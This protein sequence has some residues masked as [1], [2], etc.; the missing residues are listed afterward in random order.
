MGIKQTQQDMT[1]QGHADQLI[2][3]FGQLSGAVVAFSGGVDS[4]VVAAAAHR[5]LGKRALAVTATS[6]SVSAAQL[7]WA[8]LTASEIGIRHVEVKTDEVQRL[9]YRE[10][11]ARRCFF[12]KQ[13]LY[14]RLGEL[15]E[16]EGWETLVSGTNLDDL[17]DYRPGIEAG[18]QAGV[19]APLAELGL[20]KARVRE[21][22]RNWQLS[23]WDLPA[24]PCLASRI[25]Y[26]VE[27]T[28]DRLKMVELAEA[29]FK[30]RGFDEVRVR[31]HE[32]E[33]ARIE[34]PLRRLAE[35]FEGRLAEQTVKQLTT[36]GFRN[37]TLDLAGLRSGNLNQ[38]IQIGELT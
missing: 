14:R 13:T 12:C 20:G 10:N 1:R 6:P 30:E 27:V 7:E 16:R 11:N 21:L 28:A 23:V 32:G 38:L 26:G 15:A 34:V 2:D 9:E 8:R 35:F 4:A 18:R 29:W 5:A 17:G 31:L 37:V 36:F 25:A 24:A 3:W 22:A 33:L 19:R